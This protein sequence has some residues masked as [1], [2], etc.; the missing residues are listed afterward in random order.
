MTSIITIPGLG[1]HE[2][3]FKDYAGALPNFDTRL[4]KLIDHRKTE[5]EIFQAV[6]KEGAVI[7]LSNCYGSI[8][9]LRALGRISGN[10]AKLIIIEP[11][12]AEFFWWRKLALLVARGILGFMRFTDRLGLRRPWLVK[13]VDYVYFSRYP[14]FVQ[15]VIDIFHQSM[16]DYF[17]KIVDLLEFSLPD[18]VETETL[19]IF[20]PR[21][22]FEDLQRRGRMLRRFSRASAEEV[23]GLTHNIVTVSRKEIIGIVGDW[24]RKRS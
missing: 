11:F 16:T 14:L 13:N 8:P 5:E 10:S 22:Y 23:S 20:S 1:G 19:L 7:I 3:V 9:A 21:G 2:S 17:A 24:L 12:F 18:L 6:A 4:L 15:P